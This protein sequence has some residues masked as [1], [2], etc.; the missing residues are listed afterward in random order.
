MVTGTRFIITGLGIQRKKSMKKFNL[1]ILSLCFLLTGCK[2]DRKAEMPEH[3]TAIM[4]KNNYLVKNIITDYSE[5]ID[6]EAAI[7]AM[8][9]NYQIEYYKVSSEDKAIEMFNV[10]KEKFQRSKE[11]SSLEKSTSIGNYSKYVLKV[12]SRYKV[13][14]RIGDTLIYADVPES[15]EESTKKVLKELEY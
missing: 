1:M 14:S 12:N 11:N 6:I 5:N 4:R 7:I 8:R 13:V 10:N 9:D 15:E 3:F 2:I